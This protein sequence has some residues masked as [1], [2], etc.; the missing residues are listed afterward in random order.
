[1]Q[2]RYGSLSHVRHTQTKNR[3]DIRRTTDRQQL[4]YEAQCMFTQHTVA[5]AWEA[6]LPSNA[7][8]TATCPC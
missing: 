5:W 4:R 2:M 6:P 1:M 8:T 7:V 3:A